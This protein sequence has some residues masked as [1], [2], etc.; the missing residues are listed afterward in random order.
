MGYWKINK[1]KAWV[2]V[3]SMCCEELYDK[4]KKACQF[5][6]HFCVVSGFRDRCIPVSCKKGLM[7]VALNR[8]AQRSLEGCATWASLTDSNLEKGPQYCDSRVDC[9]HVVQGRKRDRVSN[10]DFTIIIVMWRVTWISS[11][12]HDRLAV[13]LCGHWTWGWSALSAPRVTLRLRLALYG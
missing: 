12:R 4:F 7:S 9:V 5:S 11:S 13:S 10:S 1:S 2:R 8:C 6:S 3:I